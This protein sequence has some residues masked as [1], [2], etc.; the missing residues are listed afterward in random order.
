MTNQEIYNQ[1]TENKK[2][3]KT[4]KDEE[5]GR[6]WE[7]YRENKNK[8]YY[9]YYEFFSGCGWR[10][11]GKQEGFFTKDAIEWEFDILV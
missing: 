1:W 8:Y 5:N 3:V 9:K 2:L 7:I 4:I 11:I 10:Q 6:K